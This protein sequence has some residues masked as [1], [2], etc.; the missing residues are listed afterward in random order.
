M[1]VENSQ[2]EGQPPTPAPRLVFC[3]R[4][5]RELSGL[6]AP[7]LPGPAGQDIFDNVSAKAWRE[8]QQLQTMLINEHHLSLV[9]RDARAYLSEQM[10]RFLAGEETDRPAGYTPPPRHSPPDSKPAG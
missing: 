7:P 5:R 4:Y 9:D 10:R 6:N 8:W 3:R 2:S 1:T